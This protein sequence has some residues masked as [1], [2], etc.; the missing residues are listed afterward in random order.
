MIDESCFIIQ[1]DI[2]PEELGNNA[3][4]AISLHGDVDSVVKQV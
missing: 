4:D 1:V 2:H 3:P